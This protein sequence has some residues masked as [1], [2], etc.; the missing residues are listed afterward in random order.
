MPLFDF[1][2]DFFLV[3]QSVR[4]GAVTPT[5]FNVIW[6]NTGMKPDHMQRITY[7]LTHLYYNWPGTIRFVC[8][9][10]SSLRSF[11]LFVLIFLHCV[12]WL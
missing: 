1:R 7:K 6:D 9:N 2:Y 5:S 8:V 12:Y 4:Q 10:L 3:P 11:D